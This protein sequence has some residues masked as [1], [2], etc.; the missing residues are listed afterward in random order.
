[1]TTKLP[2]HPPVLKRRDLILGLGYLM[3]EPFTVFIRD[4]SHVVR[5]KIQIE[6]QK[7]KFK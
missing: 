1:M 4:S 6:M 7:I 2:C 3:M 5:K